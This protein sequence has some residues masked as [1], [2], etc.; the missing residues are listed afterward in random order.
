MAHKLVA[1]KE[2][3][4]VGFSC[5]LESHDCTVSP[6]NTEHATHTHTRDCMSST[7]APF[8]YFYFY[9]VSTFHPQPFLQKKKK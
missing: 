5:F 2:G 7:R 1:L 4:Q 9:R 8:I 3:N 6:R